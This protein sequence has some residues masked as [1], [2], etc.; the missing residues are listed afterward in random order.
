MSSDFGEYEKT[1]GSYYTVWDSRA[2]ESKIVL[3]SLYLL[4]Y[5]P[6]VEN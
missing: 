1:W 2:R 6:Y 4:F 5:N 3:F